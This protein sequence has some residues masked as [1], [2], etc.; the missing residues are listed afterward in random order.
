MSERGTEG[1]VQ[2][3]APCLA[4]RGTWLNQ[5]DEKPSELGREEVREGVK[6]GMLTVNKSLT[7]RLGHYKDTLMLRLLPTHTNTRGWKGT[8]ARR[9]GRQRRHRKTRLMVMSLS[10]THT[11]KHARLGEDKEGKEK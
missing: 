9:R 5:E 3:S 1:D 4:W 10:P 11:H 7:P 8:R 6:E 2:F